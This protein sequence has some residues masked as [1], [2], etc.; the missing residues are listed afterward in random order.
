VVFLKLQLIMFFEGFRSERQLMD[1]VHLNLAYRWYPGYGL[2]EPVP[3]HSTPSKIRDRQGLSVFPLLRTGHAGGYRRRTGVGRWRLPLEVAVADQKYGT[4]GNILALA[5]AGV[6]AYVPLMANGV[7]RATKLF[8]RSLCVYDAE[9]D[10]AICTVAN[11]PPGRLRLKPKAYQEA[12]NTLKGFFL[13]PFV[14]F[15]EVSQV[16]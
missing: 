12:G 1:Q 13:R 8:P 10:R 9:Q 15:F 3:N 2:D 6:K 14:A 16:F 11:F 4:I 7:N 5:Q